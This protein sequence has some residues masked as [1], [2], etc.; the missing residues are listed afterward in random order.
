RRFLARQNPENIYLGDK[1]YVCTERLGGGSY[2]TCYM[3]TVNDQ[4]VALKIAYCPND[5]RLKVFKNELDILKALDHTHIVRYQRDFAVEELRIIEM[6]LCLGGTLKNK[7]KERWESDGIVGLPEDDVSRWMADVARAL[8]YLHEQCRLVH[9][10][11]KPENVVLDNI[12]RAKLCDFGQAF[13]LENGLEM[14]AWGTKGYQPPEVLQM[15]EYGE[16]IDVYAFG[17]MVHCLLLSRTPK[18]KDLEALDLGK[19]SEQAKELI[20]DCLHRNPL[21]R[22]SFAKVLTYEFLTGTAAV[23]VHHK[24]PLGVEEK[25]DEEHTQKRAAHAAGSPETNSPLSHRQTIASTPVIDAASPVAITSPAVPH[26][27]STG[28]ASS[29]SSFILPLSNI[30]PTGV[31]PNSAAPS[32]RSLSNSSTSTLPPAPMSCST[33]EKK[34]SSKSSSEELGTWEPLANEE[35]PA[36][37]EAKPVAAIVSTICPLPISSIEGGDDNYDAE[38]FGSGE[39]LQDL[40]L[41]FNSASR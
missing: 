8:G 20:Q 6:E 34:S 26:S 11:L 37:N 29:S 3:A 41:P 9:R 28:V 2:G 1:T 40:P 18:H 22:P 21:H 38:D 35:Q 12:G 24:R 5:S 30:N 32:S 16:K 39:L 19:A 36:T 31:D 7:L 10:D 33:P 14:K 17:A 4:E 15:A 23:D 25:N 13:W 27:S